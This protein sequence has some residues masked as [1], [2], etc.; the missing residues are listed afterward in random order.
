M[1]AIIQTVMF[2]L[3]FFMMKRIP[4]L[5]HYFW[6][7]VTWIQG[8]KKNIHDDSNMKG[9]LFVDLWVIIH[10]EQENKSQ[11]KKSWQWKFSTH[12]NVHAFLINISLFSINSHLPQSNIPGILL[13]YLFLNP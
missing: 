12:D 3:C 7:S 4:H 13:P 8:N 1:K 5:F 11:K 9:Y 2:V 10:K 6:E